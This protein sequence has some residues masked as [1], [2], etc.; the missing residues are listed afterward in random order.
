MAW[1]TIEKAL[2]L[3]GKDVSAE[4][5]AMASAVITL[6]AGRTEDEPA[7]AIT[8]RDRNWLAMATAYQAAWMKPKLA[9]GYFD[10]RESHTSTAADGVQ[11][12]RESD[13]QLTLAPLA[14]RTLKNLSWIGNTST[15]NG[16]TMPSRLDFALEQS[17]V[18]HAWRPV[19]IT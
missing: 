3:T 8:P 5:L 4:D 16:P 9:A 2:E 15:Y 18:D 1:T 14:A 10:Q 19:D 7:D 17:D 12:T 6:Y 11:V 13:S